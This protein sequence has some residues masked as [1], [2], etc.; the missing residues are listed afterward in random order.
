MTEIEGR[1]ERKRRPEGR[2]AGHGKG[3]RWVAR[4][5]ERIGTEV[6]M[7]RWRRTGRGCDREVRRRGSC[8]KRG[9]VFPGGECSGGNARRWKR[10]EDRGGETRGEEEMESRTWRGCTEMEMEGGVA[11]R[12]GEEDDRRKVERVQWRWRRCWTAATA[13]KQGR[14][15]RLEGG[16]GGARSAAAA[17]AAAEVSA[18]PG[19]GVAAVVAAAA[20]RRAAAA[21]A[22]GLLPRP[23]V[24]SH[25]RWRRLLS[26]FS[27][28]G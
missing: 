5:R 13:A 7:M 1:S 4:E 15:R 10:G 22:V 26:F 9:W 16:G 11:E 21:A 18:W 8:K 14:R 28:D 19:Q 2:K 23:S 20:R 3:R 17:G 25:S 24:S 12:F 27:N 6:E